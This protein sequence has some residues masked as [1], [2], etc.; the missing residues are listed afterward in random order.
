VR[1]ERQPGRA[2]AGLADYRERM[3]LAHQMLDDLAHTVDRPTLAYL[4]RHL[5]ERCGPEPSGFDPVR[6]VSN[7]VKDLQGLAA[8]IERDRARDAKGGR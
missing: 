1:R 3:A 5:R 4:R 8:A 7:A 6:V 2:A